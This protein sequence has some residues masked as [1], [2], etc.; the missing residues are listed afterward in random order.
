MRL[1]HEGNSAFRLPAVERSKVSFLVLAGRHYSLPRAGHGF[2]S[3]GQ[4]ASPDEGRWGAAG[5]G[6]W[7]S[8]TPFSE[9]ATG[10]LGEGSY[11]NKRPAEEGRK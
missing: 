2:P 10:V 6:F 1:R 9:S 11:F 8:V 4:Q 5:K 3:V 7:F